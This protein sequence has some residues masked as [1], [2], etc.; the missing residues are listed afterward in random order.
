MLHVANYRPWSKE[1][2]GTWPEQRAAL[3]HVL[4]DLTEM[5]N[6]ADGD[7]AAR[8]GDSLR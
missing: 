2:A 7:N 5:P 3:L 6:A 8:Q 4:M 1:V